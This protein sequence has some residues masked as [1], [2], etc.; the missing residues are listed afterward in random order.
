MKKT[1][2]RAISFFLTLSLLTGLLIPFASAIEYEGVESM[3]V[4]ATAALLIDLDT[5]QVLYEQAADEQRYPASITKIM[6][7][8]LTLEAIG[9]GELDLNTEITVDA[10]ALADITEDSSTANLQAGEKITVKNLLYCLLL[11]SANEA[12]N[13]LAMAVSG[14]IPTF[15]ELMNQRAQEL[16]MAGTHFV[17]PHGLHNADHYST[18][19][20]IY[21]MSKQAMTHATFREI[22]STGRYTVPATNLSKAR[23]LLNTNGLL[24]SAKHY[25]YTM[26]G[27]IGIKTGSTGEA[28]YCLVAAVQKKGH[29]LV[30]VVLGAQNPTDSRGNVQRKQFTESKRLLNWGF[31]NFSDATLLDAETYLQELPV[32]FSSEASHVVVRP[33]RSVQ[34]MVPG[35][36]DPERLELRLRFHRD[37]ASAPIEAGDVLGTVTVIYAGEEYATVDMAAVSDVSFSPFMAFVSSVNTVLGNIYVRLLLLIALALVVVGLVRRFQERTKEERRAKRQLR[38]QEKIAFRQREAEA[39]QQDEAQAK[40]EKEAREQQRKE[41]LLRR[42]Q[43]AQDRQAKRA[44]EAQERQVKREQERLER[45]ERNRQLRAEREARQAEER[46]R[47]QAEREERQRQAEVRRRQEEEA[48]RQREERE[49]RQRQEREARRQEE[50]ARRRQEERQARQRE[51]RRRQ[52]QADRE[53]RRQAEWE[54]RARQADPARN[55]PPSAARPLPGTL[56]RAAPPGKSRAAGP[57]TVGKPGP[58][59]V[60]HTIHLDAAPL[61]ARRLLWS[62]TSLPCNNGSTRVTTS[63]F[64]AGPGSPRKAESPT[65]A[66]W[67]ACITSPTPIPRRPFSVTP[68]LPKT[69]GNSTGF[70]GKKCSSRGRSPTPP[71]GNWR[72]WNRRESSRPWSPKTSTVSIRLP[73]ARWSMSCMAPPCAITAPAARKNIPSLFCWKPPAFPGALSPTAA[74]SSAPMWCSMRRDWTPM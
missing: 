23:S 27:T 38:Q 74:P 22:V 61:R 31:T 13:V 20:D 51:E 49:R 35:T 46:Q 7:A 5:D 64:S 14:D 3:T 43:E 9:R 45:E 37:V 39:R 66:V 32:R 33:T 50:L 63:S 30:S 56:A 65:S 67:T 8:L 18:A 26:D 34:V 40:L 68:S 71:T 24:T 25:G 28:G 4:D 57:T 53:R 44:Q 17:N 41:E 15:V 11:A 70:I 72:S 6:T 29:T 36:Y 10:A 73:E 48:R 59:A 60:P 19:R 12:A 42:Q 16:G 69:P 54:R 52:E 58:A 21:R 1:L 47:R 2:I 55:A 62:K